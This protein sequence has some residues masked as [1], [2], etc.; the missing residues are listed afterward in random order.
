M[1][2][3]GIAPPL[4]QPGAQPGNGLCL[5]QP[6]WREERAPVEGPEPRTPGNVLN[7]ARP[8]WR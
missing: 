4:D 6:P 5:G 7:P 8:D 1:M 2:N 3:T